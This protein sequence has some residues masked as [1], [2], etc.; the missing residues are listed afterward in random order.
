MFSERPRIHC[1]KFHLGLLK[2]IA[3]TPGKHQIRQPRLLLYPTK[4][5]TNCLKTQV[6]ELHARQPKLL[7][8]D[9]ILIPDRRTENPHVIS[10]NC[11]KRHMLIYQLDLKQHQ[12]K[13]AEKISG[14]GE[15]THKIKGH[16]L[17]NH[18]SRK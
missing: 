16:L 3:L 15:N 10:L 1:I 9:Q 8:Y 14:M 12:H 6:P 4:Y 17:S 11:Q 18:Q 2:Q 5:R 13:L 7:S